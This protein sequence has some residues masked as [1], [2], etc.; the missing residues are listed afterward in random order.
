MTLSLCPVVRSNSGPILSKTVAPARAVKTL[1]SAPLAAMIPANPTNIPMLIIARIAQRAF[2]D[3]VPRNTDDRSVS[4]NIEWLN[5]REVA[6][7][8]HSQVRSPPQRLID[9]GLQRQLNPSALRRRL[10]HEDHEHIVLR[11]DKEEGAADAVPAIFAHWPGCP[12]IRQSAHGKA[13][14]E[15]AGNARK[16]KIVARDLRLRPDMVRC[17]QGNRLGFEVAPAVEGGAVQQHLRETRVV[18]DGLDQARPV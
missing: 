8:S 4:E 2:M 13:E 9:Q 17:H 10:H 18:P 15:P 6:Q 5:G 12:G 16:I 1:I 3:Q 7:Q 14:T 11:I